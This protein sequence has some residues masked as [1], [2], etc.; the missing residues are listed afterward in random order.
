MS[1]NLPFGF[2]TADG[3]TKLPANPTGS[4][5]TSEVVGTPVPADQVS[6]SSNSGAIPTI[7]NYDDS[8]TI[9]R[10]EQATSQGK[11]KMSWA[12]CLSFI[13]V[14][15]RGTFVTDSF[16]NVWRILSSSIQRF[17]S[18]FQMGNLSYTAESISFDSPP[19]DFQMIPSELGIDIIKYPRY[20]FSLY[21]QG[22][23]FTDIVGVA[24]NTATRAQVKMAII[25]AIQTYRDSPYFPPQ[26]ST[27]LNGTIQNNVINSFL[28]SL[29]PS[30][31]GAAENTINVSGDAG[32][33]LAI[34]AAS[35]VIQKLWFQLDTPY[36]AG[37]EVTWTQYFFA[38][39]Y[40]NPGGY[41]ESPVGIVPDYFISPSQDGS[42]TIFDQMALV[43]PQCYSANGE[44][45]GTVNISWLRKADEVVYERT[46]F[47]V[48][49]KWVGSPI[50]HWDAQIYS[51]GERPSSPSDYLP[52]PTNA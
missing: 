9:E 46:W 17:R 14:L 43:N 5:G 45:G 50:G 22:N 15:G 35:E 3:V 32:C 28:S 42:N 41:V 30:L 4:G 40:E 44:S 2:D 52:L 18:G 49:H 38:P 7:E 47:R 34:A 21:P 11:L 8:P 6:V 16:G 39:V 48:T 13:T 10:A 20:F 1:F 24:P 51:G 19:D 29:I 23:D 25:R 33:Q 37:F 12:A 27:S 31:N 36:L 26:G